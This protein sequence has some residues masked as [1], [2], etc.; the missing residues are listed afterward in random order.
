MIEWKE[1]KFSEFVSINPKVTFEQRDLLPFVEM[2]DI[3]PSNKFCSNSTTR[4]LS[5]GAR[6]INGDTLF[7]RITPCLENGK[8]A[9]VRNLKGG[10][11]FGST[12]FHVLRGKNEISDTDFVYYLS[13]WSD[14]RDFAQINLHGTSGRQR[15]PAEAFKELILTLPPL[16]EQERIA[17][18]L[19]SLDDK[20]DLLQRQNKTLEQLAETMF[21]QWFVE[22][23]DDSWITST[24]G[25]SFDIKGGGTPPTGEKSYWDGRICW[26]SPKDLSSTSNI[27]LHNTERKI[28]EAGLRKVSSGLLPKGVVL[29][30]SRAPIGYLAITN[31]TTAINQG[32]IACLPNELY[33]S[34]FIHNWLKVS[35]D[36]IVNSANGSTFLEIPK[37]VFRTLDFVVPT[38]EKVVSYNHQAELFYSKILSNEKQINL[39]EQTRDTLLPKL[40]SGEVMVEI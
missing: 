17:E 27:F 40:M 29:L 10:K 35:M 11:G 34:W 39:L 7:A 22:G 37:S 14:V 20:I 33:S 21:R 38:R 23:A 24:V 8:I 1:Y 13:R 25:E 18:V 30:S 16:P 28:T 3:E 36:L 9:Q 31:V 26:T 4:S 2:K 32:Y 19:S 5:G 12:E 6:F 15:F